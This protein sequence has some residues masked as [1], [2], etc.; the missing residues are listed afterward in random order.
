VEQNEEDLGEVDADEE[1][2]G[3]FDD[4]GELVVQVADAEVEVETGHAADEEGGGVDEV[5][6]EVVDFGQVDFGGREDI[7]DVFDVAAGAFVDEDDGE[8][9]EGDVEDLSPCQ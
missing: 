4:E 7:L 9:Y 6:G 2:G 8:D 3:A 1:D 5:G